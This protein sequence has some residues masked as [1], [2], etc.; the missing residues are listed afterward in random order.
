[1]ANNPK[2]ER[3]IKKSK[4]KPLR[5]GQE[6]RTGEQHRKRTETWKCEAVKHG[7]ATQVR[8]TN[9]LFHCRFCLFFF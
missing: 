5:N 6:K 3:G 8:S 2:Y 4:S 9:E 7:T 1:V